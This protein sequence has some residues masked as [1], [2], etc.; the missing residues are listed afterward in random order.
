LVVVG[1]H[2]PEFDFE[3]EV[4]NVAAASH[5]LGVT[6]PVAMDNDYGTWDAWGNNSWPAEYLID[7]QGNVRYGDVGEGRYGDMEAAIRALLAAAGHPHLP[8]TTSVADQTPAEATTPESYLGYQRLARYVGQPSTVV[9]EAP[10]RYTFASS[11]KADQ[12][13]YDG[14]WTVE[15]DDI[16]AGSGAQL[17][18]DVTAKDIYLVLGGSGTVSVTFNGQALP[19]VHVNGVPTL[20]T[21]KSSSQLQHGTLQLSVSPGV[22]AYDFTFG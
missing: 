9:H 2:T 1:V 22:R 14:T 12:L 13:S 17:R 3:H 6:Y 7:P 11:L 21:L 20:Y 18:L 8:A 5:R 15:P 16:L 19:P 10:A 4:G